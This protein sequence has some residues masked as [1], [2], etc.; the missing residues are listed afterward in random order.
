[1]QVSLLEWLGITNGTGTDW[2][3]TF[4]SSQELLCGAQAIAVQRLPCICQ[5]LNFR[6]QSG[7]VCWVQLETHSLSKTQLL[8]VLL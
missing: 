8:I 2:H 1:M 5:Q 3:R 6:P 7:V 4:E